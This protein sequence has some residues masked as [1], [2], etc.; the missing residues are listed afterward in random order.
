MS[1]RRNVLS[2]HLEGA[3][4]IARA[5]KT[6][7]IFVVLRIRV[8]SNLTGTLLALGVR[9]C[10]NRALLVV[11]REGQYS[12]ARP[13]MLCYVYQI[14]VKCIVNCWPNLALFSQVS[15]TS[16]YSTAKP[17]GFISG[18]AKTRLTAKHNKNDKEFIFMEENKK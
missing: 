2:S 16:K 8:R 5:H 14:V 3:W 12:Q 10:A 6:F 9:R 11:K 13:L 7:G 4:A 17:D 15:G 1:I 18:S